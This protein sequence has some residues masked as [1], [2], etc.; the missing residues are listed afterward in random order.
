MSEITAREIMNVRKGSKKTRFS[1]QRYVSIV[2]KEILQLR[3]DKISSRI[4][5]AMPIM[6]MLLFGYAV[7][8]EVDHIKTAVFDQSQTRESREYID[9]FRYTNYFTITA[10][11]NSEAEIESLIDSGAAKAGILIPSTFARDIK[12]GKNPQ[13]LLIIDGSDSTVAQ[14]ILS[15]GILIAQN[16][17]M[18]RMQSRL[19]RTGMNSPDLQAFGVNTRVMYNP[20]M[21]VRYFT[22]PG[23]VGVILMNITIMLTAFAM[24]REKERGTIEQL[25]VTPIKSNELILGKLTPYIF[26]GY[27]GFLFSLGICRFLFGIRIL[28]SVWTLLLLAALFVICS[29]SIGMLISTFARTQLQA[30][31]MVIAIILP[32]IL[33]SGFMFPIEAMPRFLQFITYAIPLTYFLRID[34]GIILKGVGM[35]IIWR[36]ALSLFIFMIVILFIAIRKFKKNLD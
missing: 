12:S 26:T 5:I 3:R 30:M 11:A 25:I 31:F 20:N 23:L 15:S 19:A 18:R 29:L 22:I 35:D 2:K 1:F 8:T 14:T 24:V 27:I 32:G 7:N 17:Y 36:D 9:K 16:D 10:Q 13:T 33:L 28:G 4:P 21:E 34:R 6:M